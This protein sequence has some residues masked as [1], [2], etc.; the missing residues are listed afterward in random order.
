MLLS[1]TVG[2]IRRLPDRLLASFESTLAEVAEAQLLVFVVDASDHER[3]L[4][5][6]T[7][8]DLVEKIGAG[9]VPRFYVFNKIDR[10]HATPDEE[11]FE[12]WSEGHPWAALSSHDAGA[13]AALE[14]ALLRAVRREEAV[15]S[16]LVPYEASEVLAL[17]YGKCRVLD[18][19]AA[20]E[21]LRLRVQGP[22]PVISRIRAALGEEGR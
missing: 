18:S 12:A 2:F 14:E 16:T 22:A 21:G 6:S 5:L 9:D 15:L 17:V 11:D 20:D 10:L 19:A 3:A 1:D 7:T 4:H 13:V 8:R